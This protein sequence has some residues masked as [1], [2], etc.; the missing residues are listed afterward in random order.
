MRV[1]PTSDT[2]ARAIAFA[3]ANIGKPWAKGAMG[4]D[5]YSCWGLAHACQRE[6]FG[7]DLPIVN[8]DESDHRAIVKAIQGHPIKHA[9]RQYPAPRHGD[10]VELARNADPA[11]VG[12][13]LAI[14]R[15]GILHAVKAGGV[16]FDSL[17]T[18]PALGWYDF[19]YWRP[20]VAA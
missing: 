17:Q 12:T 6:V 19:R 7:H 2:I 13:Y 18:L 15:G 3:Q 16:R 8:V 10:L 5:V 9:W 14:D 1:L 20:Q 4:P 11:H